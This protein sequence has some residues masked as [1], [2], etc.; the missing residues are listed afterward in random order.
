M[1]GN[2]STVLKACQWPKQRPTTTTIV[3][4]VK[5]SLFDDEDVVNV[6]KSP[7]VCLL[8]EG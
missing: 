1:V 6:N 3:V 5:R 8:G 7:L 4:V 2:A